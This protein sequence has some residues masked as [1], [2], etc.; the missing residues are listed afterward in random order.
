MALLATLFMS[1][2]NSVV[3][4][5]NGIFPENSEY[6]PVSQVSIYSLSSQQFNETLDR[7]QKV[8][9]PVIASKGGRL[10]IHRLWNDGT[11][12]ASADRNGGV[13]NLNMYGGLARHP[14]VTPDAFML[15][16]CHEL[17]HHLGGAPKIDTFWS[18]WASNEGEAD[19]FAGLKCFR[20]VFTDQENL[21]WLTNADVH[22]TVKAKCEQTWSQPAEQAVCMRFAMAGYAITSM[23]KEIKYRDAPLDFDKPDS[24]QVRQT[25]DSHPMP[26]C[27]LDTY[28]QS[29][30][31]T[32]SVDAQLSDTNPDQGTCS[33][34]HG[35]AEGVRPLCW[36]KP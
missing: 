5:C 22:P 2:Q 20:K 9:G 19:Y 28:F 33:R 7:I 17:G 24:S 14:L 10:A 15:V 36:Y 18:T 6:I 8:Y 31:C 35:D 27:R 16:A 3:Q 29:A 30:L 21:D 11:V 26:Q 1:Q 13:Y 32:A 25:D 34:S 12:N 4:L 23:F